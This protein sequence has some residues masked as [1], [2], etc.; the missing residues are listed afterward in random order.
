MTH[1]PSPAANRVNHLVQ[2]LLAFREK[3]NGTTQEL[4][5]LAEKNF[6][7]PEKHVLGH[8]DW[9][10]MFTLVRQIGDDVNALTRQAAVTANRDLKMSTR[11][12]GESLNIS[13]NTVSR[14]VRKEEESNTQTPPA[15][16][17][18]IH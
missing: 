15:S 11:K 5:Q 3:L 7:T 18:P 17:K 9:D 12:V 10:A 16:P 13:A 8:E 4:Q 6:L 1:D 14:W 2:E